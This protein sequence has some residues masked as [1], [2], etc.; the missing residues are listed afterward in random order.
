VP[1]HEALARAD[2]SATVGDGGI[3]IVEVGGAA[4]GATVSSGGTQ[5]DARTRLKGIRVRL[6]GRPDA[7]PLRSR[8]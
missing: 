8:K 2:T 6:L 1:G 3:Q 5:T 4:I 7:Y